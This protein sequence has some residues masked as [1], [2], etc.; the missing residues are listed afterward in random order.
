MK[1]VQ[2]TAANR[3]AVLN[4]K[5]EQNLAARVGVF[6]NSV[7]TARVKDIS[8][9]FC[10]VRNCEARLVSKAFTGNEMLVEL[11]ALK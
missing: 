9:P 7:E 3:N 10:F 5:I 8:D 2:C 11:V 6:I 4:V 1:G